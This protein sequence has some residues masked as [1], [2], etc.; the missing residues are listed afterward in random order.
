A[1]RAREELSAFQTNALLTERLP[2][3]LEE[4]AI[5]VRQTE[6]AAGVI[7][8]SAE[9][10]LSAE[11]EDA[12]ALREEVTGH[13][14]DI[15]QACGFQDITGQRIQKA[16]KCL[17]QI[18]LRAARLAASLGIEDSSEETEDEAA[19]RARAEAL[20]LHGPDSPEDAASQDDVDAVFSQDDIDALFD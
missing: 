20:H 9:A 12:D 3:A 2:T 16:S 11:A 14:L 17:E 8:A 4:L 1:A 10:I 5:V 15:L 19:A 18:E 7:L 6:E 13:A